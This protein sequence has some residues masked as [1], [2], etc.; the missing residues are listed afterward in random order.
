LANE[1]SIDKEGDKQPVDKSPTQAGATDSQQKKEE[2]S[3]LDSLLDKQEIQ[4][5][6]KLEIAEL[7]SNKRFAGRVIIF[8]TIVVAFICI[9]ELAMVL[10]QL[11]IDVLLALTLASAMAPMAEIGEKRGV[12]R[13]ATVAVIYVVVIAFYASLGL[14]VSK[15]FKEQVIV[16]VDQVPN[17]IDQI[18]GY[19]LKALDLAG[20]SATLLKIEPSSLKA[21]GTSVF[22]KTITATATLFEIIVNT[23]LVLFL[24]AFFVVDAKDIWAGL[25]KWVPSKHRA[26][27]GSLIQPLENRMG[28]YV[29]GQI[30]VC[31]AVAIFFAVGF[32]LI[33]VKYGLVLGLIA[34]LLNLIPFVG[35]MIAT[36]IALFIAANQSVTTFVLTLVLFL[37]EQAVESN[38]IV[39]HLLGKQVELHPLIVLFSILI[40]ATIAGAAGAVVAVP[41]IA[42]ML[43]LTREFL[44]TPDDPS[45]NIQNT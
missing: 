26:K 21:A 11:I 1:D 34:G 2:V 23:I 31:T 38:F 27:A 32:T 12:P 41:T 29:R 44:I 36:L 33:G 39:P 4:N 43:Y 15:P 20:D 10:K 9:V 24:S 42:V 17:Y 45:T 18:H 7:A 35:S 13:A 40:G 16:F 3:E 28:G 14:L 6:K 37:I 22:L 8:C 19:Y 30:L 25:L 5:L